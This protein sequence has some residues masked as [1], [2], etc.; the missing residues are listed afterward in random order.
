MGE[1]MPS[2]GGGGWSKINVTHPKE[3][4]AIWCYEHVI[5]WS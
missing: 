1:E 2:S 3:I 5:V 4:K